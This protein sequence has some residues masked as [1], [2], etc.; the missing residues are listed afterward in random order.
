MGGGHP[1][2]YPPLRTLILPS[3]TPLNMVKMKGQVKHG[4][5]ITITC[6]RKKW[7]DLTLLMD[8]GQI[9]QP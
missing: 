9:T 8:S 6:I 7:A 1:L 2:P 4:D 5:R 3:G